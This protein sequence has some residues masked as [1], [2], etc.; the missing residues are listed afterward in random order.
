MPKSPLP[1][2]APDIPASYE[3]AMAELEELVGGLESGELPLE[4]MLSGYQ[5]GA[6]LLQFCRDKLQAVENQIKVLDDGALKVWK[7]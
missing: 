1:T 7:A 6:Q 5:R 3:L 4:Q 2:N